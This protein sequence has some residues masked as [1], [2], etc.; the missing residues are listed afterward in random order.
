MAEWVGEG[1]GGEVPYNKTKTG[2]RCPKGYLFQFRIDYLTLF[3]TF[4]M[5]KL[6]KSME[7]TPL[8]RKIAKS[9][10]GIC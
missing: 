10:S 1:G 7:R 3:S 6:N 9:K 5:D 2:R 4:D 8:T